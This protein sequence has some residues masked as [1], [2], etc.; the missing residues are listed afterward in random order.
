ME[1]KMN[2]YIM[3]VSGLFTQISGLL[4]VWVIFQKIPHI[5]GWSI[6]EV[7]FIYAMVIFSEGICSL[8]FD[9]VFAWNQPTVFLYKKR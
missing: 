7:A 6:W 9:G 2:F 1:Y 5:N 4:F 3:L 8:F